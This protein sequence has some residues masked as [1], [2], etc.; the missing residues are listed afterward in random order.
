MH[1]ARGARRRRRS[2]PR[3]HSSARCWSFLEKPGRE[4]DEGI[5]EVRG[6]RRHFTH[7][8]VMAWVAFDRA[9]KIGGAASRLDGWPVERWRRLRAAIHDGGVRAGGSTAS[10][11]PSRSTTGRSSRRQP[12]DDAAG[13]FPAG[14][15]S[16]DRGTVE[17]IERELMRDGFLQRATRSIRGSSDV[18]G[19]PA[20]RGRVSRLH[21]LA[22]G[23]L[24][25]ARTRATR[26]TTCSSG[27]W[28]CATTGTAVG[29]V[30]HHAAAPRRQLSAGVL[31]RLARQHRQEPV[32]PRRTGGGSA[33]A[34]HTVRMSS[35]IRSL[36]WP[37]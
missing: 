9:V 10:A 2:E 15:R 3:G 7:S 13:R 17:A 29:G 12:A 4:P 37:F 26:R 35:A 36:G 18:D 16:A 14:A 24:R 20:R 19:L 25:A 11:T 21:V 23:Q 6:P 34:R 30:R 27:S 5:W 28:R 31:A 8:K 32:P 22:G 1:Q 33:R